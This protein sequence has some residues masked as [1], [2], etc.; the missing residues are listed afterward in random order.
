MDTTLTSNIADQTRPGAIRLPCIVD[1]MRYRTLLLFALLPRLATAQTDA[2]RLHK[3][4]AD[5][6][7]SRLRD[8]PEAATSLGRNE[9]N[10]LWTDWSPAAQE[11]RR[12]ENE[13]YLRDLD[14]FSPAKLDEQDRLSWQL[15]GYQI[16]QSVEMQPLAVF[17]L[18]VS[19]MF[20]LHTSVFQTIDQMPTRTVKDYENIIARLN[21][22]PVYI[23]QRIANLRE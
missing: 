9:Y 6:Y 21:A 1:I 12:A 22:L 17:L 2:D 23:D 3:L 8:A 19:Q 5:Y 20:G 10:R 13:K 14:T 11:R 15:L 18:P 4:F 7:E 16:H